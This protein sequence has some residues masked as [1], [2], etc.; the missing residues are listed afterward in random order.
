MD[1]GPDR[2]DNQIGVEEEEDAGQGQEDREEGDP[3]GEEVEAG[4]WEGLLW[5]E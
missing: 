3:P 4:V 2:A 1:A 5:E